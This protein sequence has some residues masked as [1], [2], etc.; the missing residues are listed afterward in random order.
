[1]AVRAA[2]ACG[3]LLHL[4]RSGGALTISRGGNAQGEIHINFHGRNQPPSATSAARSG[5]GEP[6]RDG[7]SAAAGERHAGTGALGR[8]KVAHTAQQRPPKGAGGLGGQPPAQQQRVAAGGLGRFLQQAE[9]VLASSAPVLATASD[10]E[11]GGACEVA[12]KATTLISWDLKEFMKGEQ[13]GDS[14][15]GGGGGGPSGAPRC[16]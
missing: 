14:G 4:L 16:C 7:R 10:A 13:V 3:V 5:V 12:P 6:S 9:M 1:M 2:V 15:G 11:S 8:P